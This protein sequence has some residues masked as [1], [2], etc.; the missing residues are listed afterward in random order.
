MRTIG[1]LVVS[2]F[3]FAAARPS[4]AAEVTQT[5]GSGSWCS[6][7]Q[8][9]N[10]D[11]VTCNG[12]DPRAEH[13]LNDLLDRMNLDLKQ[14]TDEANDWAR[15]YK[16]LNAQLEEMKKQLAAKGEDVTL[17]E[18]A[19]DLLHQG[20]LEEARAIFDRLIQSDEA[21][22]DRAG[23]DYFGRATVFALQFRFDEALPDCAKA[24]QYRPNDQGY[25]EAYAYALWQKDYS[26]MEA[27]L[28]ELLKQQRP[29]RRKTR[30]QLGS[31]LEV[32]FPTLALR[33]TV[34]T[35]ST[36]PKPLSRRPSKFTRASG[37]ILP[38]TGLI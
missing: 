26:K 22:V 2:L 36:A 19:Q 13:Y 37:A 33:T 14:K 32:R 10:N 25:A 1:L 28:Q 29:L 6:P 31:F 23:Q 21:N 16:E 34:C 30:S 18:S 8:N 15:R 17:V 38:P 11:N 20:K 12:V 3:A 35:A 27:V 24:Y 4:V 5:T 9:G 7:A